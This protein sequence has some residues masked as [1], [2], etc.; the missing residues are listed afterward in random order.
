MN[1]FGDRL[2][3]LRR[4]RDITQTELAEYLGVV[5]S[6]VGKYERVPQAYPSVEVLLKI[7][8]YFNVSTDYLLKGVNTAPIV[9]NTIHGSLSNSAL[10]QANQGG[11]VFSGDSSE[12][13]TPEGMELLHIYKALDGRNRLML[14]NYAINLEG[15]KE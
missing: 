6:A 4:D 15:S 13:L 7:A 8:D 10:I 3:R 5:P 2:K 1:G 11:V 9:E 12:A 14:L